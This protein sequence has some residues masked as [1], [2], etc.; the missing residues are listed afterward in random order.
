MKIVNP[1]YEILSRISSN[2]S[3]ELKMIELAA[4][5]CYKSEGKITVDDYSA[6]RMCKN[7][8]KNQHEAMI[9]HSQLSVKLVVDRAIANELV[10]HRV[11]SFAQEST[12]YCNY[13]ND[14][15]ANEIT[16][17]KPSEIDEDSA[18]FVVWKNQMESAEK[19]YFD[20]I[21]FGAKAENARSVLPLCLKA[22]IVVTANYREWRHIFNLR[23]APDAHPDIRSILNELLEDLKKK[24][25][26]IF[27]DIK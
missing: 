7:L 2:G 25:P 11:A 4:R 15:F 5:T 19:A 6:R 21:G 13:S 18:Q 26:V 27:D 20:M 8:I 3:K 9:E 23:T 12:R 1:S 22:E 14:R 17:I 10:R 16:V 24:I